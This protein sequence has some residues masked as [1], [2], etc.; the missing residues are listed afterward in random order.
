MSIAIEKVSQM[1]LNL[2]LDFESENTENNNE[3]DILEMIE[4]DLILVTRAIVA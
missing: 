3:E 2:V 4:V 1:F